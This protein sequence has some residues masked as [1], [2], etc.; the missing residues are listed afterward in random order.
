[1]WGDSPPLPSLCP[2]ESQVFA[3]LVSQS[4]AVRSPSWSRDGRLRVG[5]P[6]D[7]R[8]DRGLLPEGVALGVLGEYLERRSHHQCQVTCYSHHCMLLHYLLPLSCQHLNTFC[9]KVSRKFLSFILSGREFSVS[10]CRLSKTL[11]ASFCQVFINLMQNSPH[12]H[13][14]AEIPPH[15]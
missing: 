10:S 14:L 4:T 6:G 7:R 5:I 1:M 11:L 15:S 9:F 8:D 12:I 3:P 2:Q 13:R